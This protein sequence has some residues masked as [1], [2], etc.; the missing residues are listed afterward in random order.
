M[1]FSKWGVRGP[2]MER[3]CKSRTEA[4]GLGQ[5]LSLLCLTL[6]RIVFL[7]PDAQTHLGRPVSQQQL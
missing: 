1:L 3:T 6:A 2:E 5:G 7:A 4:A